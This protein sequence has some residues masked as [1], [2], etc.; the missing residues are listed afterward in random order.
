VRIAAAAKLNHFSYSQLIN[1]LKKAGVELDRKILARS[2]EGRARLYQAVDQ[3]KSA[4]AAE[5]KAGRRQPRS[6]PRRSLHSV[7][8]IERAARDPADSGPF[9][10]CV[11][12]DPPGCRVIPAIAQKQNRAERRNVY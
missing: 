4:L 8:R 1:G 9:C 12:R 11:A 2:P 5:K 3:A 7:R 10:V 6:P